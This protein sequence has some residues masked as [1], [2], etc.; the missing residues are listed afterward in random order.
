MRFSREVPQVIGDDLTFEV[1]QLWQEK[2]HPALLGLQDELAD[3]RLVKELARSMD[4]KD[5]RNFGEW[6][7]GTYIT[8]A[9][10]TA[11]DALATGL[12]ATAAGGVATVV[13]DAVRAR[14]EG[15]ATAKSNE[16]YYLYAANRRLA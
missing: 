15:Q 1:E 2:V 5:V 11:L 9:S 12:I 14:R 4:V 6:T 7:A 10:T 8:V 3:H 13:L 16:F